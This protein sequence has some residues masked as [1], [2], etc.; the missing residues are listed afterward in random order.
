[1]IIKKFGREDTMPEFGTF[2]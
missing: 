2:T 1:V